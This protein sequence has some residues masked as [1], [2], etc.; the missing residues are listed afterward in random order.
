MLKK[1]E[2]EFGMS[3]TAKHIKVLRGDIAQNILLPG[4]P[5]RARYMAEKFLD[6]VVCYNEVRGMYGYTGTYKG[7]KV[8]VQG[9]GMGIP[10][11]S[12]YVNE[13]IQFFGAKKLIRVGTCG[14]VRSDI[15]LGDL[16]MAM[17]ASNE[18]SMNRNRFGDLNY[19]PTASFNLLYHAYNTA[20]ERSQKVF[21]GKIFTGDN[22]YSSDFLKQKR[23]LM[24]EYGILGSDMETAELY[25]LAAKYD[26]DAL[27][28]LQVTDNIATGECV[29]VE[30]R[31]K[32]VDDMVVLALESII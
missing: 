6:N 3:N 27:T 31:E 14:T 17:S 30:E 23:K 5:L 18:T 16:I 22:F 7:K 24:F 21:C 19:A 29:S 8:S 2:W 32:K 1:Q 13:L 15:D 4:D 10:S 25:T 26:V 20:K 9:T 12:I 28:L 11:I